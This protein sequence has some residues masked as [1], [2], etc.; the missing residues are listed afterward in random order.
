MTS[1]SANII[2]AVFVMQTG[3]HEYE[4]DSED[5]DKSSDFISTQVH[6]STQ[7]TFSSYVNGLR[8]STINPN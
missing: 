8:A 1:A 5:N 7:E 4:V 3:T 2:S 6:S